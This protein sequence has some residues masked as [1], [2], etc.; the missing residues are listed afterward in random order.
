MSKR[1]LPV[2]EWVS[3][4]ELWLVGGAAAA[5]F[6]SSR[7]LP[8]APILGAAF[9]GLR[10]ARTRRLGLP[11]PAIWPIAG[12][13]LMLPVTL[14]V[15]TQPEISLPQVLRLLGGM[16]LY[17]AVFHWA[18]VPARLRLAVL[19]VAGAAALL[20]VFAVFSVEWA[21]GK[22]PF[23]P[24][25]VYERFEILVADT[26][27]RNVMAGSLVIL[28]PL[29]LAALVFL[30][31][32]ARAWSAWYLLSCT[33]LAGGMLVLTQSRGGL[34]ALGAAGLLL[35]ALRWRG[36][37]LL[38]P[39][40]GLIG[41]G[42]GLLLGWRRLAEF[43]S[44]GVDLGGLDGRLELWSRALTMIRDFPFTGI[45]MGT[46][47]AVVTAFY[48]LFLNTPEKTVHSHNLILQIG[49]DLGLPGLICWLAVW[50]LS[51]RAAWL[52]YRNGRQA[53]LAWLAAT[54]AGLLCAQ[55]ALLV[56]GMFDAVTWGMVRPAPLV[57]MLWGLAEAARACPLEAA[58]AEGA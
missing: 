39:L 44:A 27:H 25:W 58:P 3:A 28:L 46:F 16:A 17:L 5:A 36:G 1:S 38:T 18:R 30:P 19:G 29:P 13:L 32:R 4:A 6:L 57:W 31:W 15:T 54:G 56:H 48:P 20:A 26:V 11:T 7:L 47:Q 10:L 53:G 50:G 9:T 49:V 22:L 43:L 37:W 42:G 52:A 35:A 34:L 24:A 2:L 8:L 41:L 33:L 21:M 51:S 45:G 40:A 12:L 23:I 14:W 55:A